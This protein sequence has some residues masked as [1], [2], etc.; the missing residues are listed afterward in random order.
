MDGEDRQEGGGPRSSEPLNEAGGANLRFVLLSLIM[1]LV[2]IISGESF[3]FLKEMEPPLVFHG[4]NLIYCV[5]V[6]MIYH[7][8]SRV[9]QTFSL[10]SVLRMMNIGMPTFF[11]LTVFW[12][13][14]IYAPVIVGALLVVYGESERKGLPDS[15]LQYIKKVRGTNPGKLAIFF[16]TGIAA[17]AILGSIEFYILKPERL[18]PDFNISSILLLFVVM[19]VFVGFGEELIFRYLLQNR[20]KAH[21]GS[22]EAILITSFVF[23]LMH[24]GYSSLLYLGYVFVIGLVFGISYERTK[25]LFF[26][27]VLHGAINFFLFSILPFIFS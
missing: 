6:S 20:I 7:E 5:L 18:I 13:P 14:F 17:G 26:V 2:F 4:L 1:P 8:A 12:L 3:F 9:L 16:I 22:W 24:S 15:I 10:I 21:T 23:A 19:F 27:S 11:N 25:S